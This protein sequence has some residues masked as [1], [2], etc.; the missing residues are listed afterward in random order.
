M[1]VWLF[2][3][4]FVVLAAVVLLSG[5]VG[6]RIGRAREGRERQG[7]DPRWAVAAE[8]FAR[9]VVAPPASSADLDDLVVL[10]VGL[11]DQGRKLLYAAPGAAQRRLDLRRRGF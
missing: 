8:D 1:K 11:R 4:P 7:I 3:A 9:Q 6:V 10:P 5:W 2:V